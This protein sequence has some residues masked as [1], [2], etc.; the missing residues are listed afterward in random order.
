MKKDPKVFVRH[1]LE[2]IANIDGFTK[3]MT[4]QQFLES[5]E[6]QSAV[7][8]QLAMI[9]EASKNLP[10]ALREKHKSTNWK[11]IIGLKN[12]IVHE[13]FGVDKGVIWQIIKKDI[14]SLKSVALKMLEENN[15]K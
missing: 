1:I 12:I 11:A 14:P 15:S 2:S 5:V 13:Y 8:M 10:L 6:K 9:G 3:G 4:E 7:L